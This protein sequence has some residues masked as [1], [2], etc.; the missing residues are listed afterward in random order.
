M[1]GDSVGIE[2]IKDSGARER[3][4]GKIGQITDD[5]VELDTGRFLYYRTASRDLR[6]HYH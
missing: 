5:V 3:K 1:L 4:N 6:R 2:L